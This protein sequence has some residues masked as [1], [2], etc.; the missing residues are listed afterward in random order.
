V[1]HTFIQTTKS[2]FHPLVAGARTPVGGGSGILLCGIGTAESSRLTL[3]ASASSGSR[4]EPGSRNQPRCIP[5]SLLM[6]VS[7]RF[8]PP[9][10]HQPHQYRSLNLHGARPKPVTQKRALRT[11]ESI[12]IHFLRG[13][14]ISLQVG[15][16]M[17]G[18]A[19]QRSR[20][21]MP[22]QATTL[23]PYSVMRN[24]GM[25]MTHL[26]KALRP[27]TVDVFQGTFGGGM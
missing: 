2:I 18:A 19:L 7:V 5:A 8:E 14:W 15:L 1:F 13:D 21:S 10:L 17:A 25:V 24:P 6:P 4:S 3:E 9:S 22:P 27:I 16:H 11:C 20:K 26:E 23:R 12:S